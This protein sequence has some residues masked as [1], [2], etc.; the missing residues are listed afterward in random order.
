[1]YVY[2]TCNNKRE[3]KAMTHYT[4]YTNGDERKNYAKADNYESAV[5]FAMMAIDE[6][7]VPVFVE[8]GEMIE[9]FSDFGNGRIWHK[10]AKKIRYNV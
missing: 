4:I 3:D 5:K 2:Y 8:Y 6:L 9:M 7:K 1:M 10:K